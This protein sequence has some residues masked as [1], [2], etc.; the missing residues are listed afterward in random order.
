[1]ACLGVFTGCGEVVVDGDPKD[2]SVVLE[3]SKSRWSFDLPGDGT[4]NE[5]GYVG[6][7]CCTGE[8]AVV[9]ADDG[10]EIGYAY[11]YSWEGPGYFTGPDS[12]AIP[13]VTVLIAA[14]TDKTTVPVTI[15]QGEIAFQA[16]ELIAGTSRSA[17]V[18]DLVFNV[19]V[20][21]AEILEWSGETM[22]D[23]GSLAVRVD[24]DPVSAN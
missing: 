8:T 23:M 1:M 3:E 11:F 19:I 14:V 17:Q 13:N 12:S 15:E 2:N 4:P 22:V 6:P 7:F 16:A 21:H 18:G 5:N 24:V 20:T 10:S 9:K